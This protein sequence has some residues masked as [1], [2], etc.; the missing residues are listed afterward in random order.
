MTLINDLLFSGKVGGMS[1]KALTLHVERAALIATNIANAST[2]GYKA[3]DLAPFEEALAKSMRNSVPMTK[4]NSGHIS[5]ATDN[6]KTFHPQVIESTDPGRIDG[7][8]VN[9]DKEIAKQSENSLMYQT[10][11]TIRAKRLKTNGMAIEGKF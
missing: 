4:T 6:I 3:Q 7:N 9:M 1:K 11:L 5:G 10:I 2:P 8:N